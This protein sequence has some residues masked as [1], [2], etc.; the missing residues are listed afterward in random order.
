MNSLVSLV[1][2][3]LS[4]LKHWLWVRYMRIR[5]PKR[6]PKYPP[7]LWTERED[8]LWKIPGHNAS[9]DDETNYEAY[10]R[11]CFKGQWPK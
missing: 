7:S 6:T 2:V 11:T 8:G 4:K 3:K 5:Y 9:P 10:P 1:S